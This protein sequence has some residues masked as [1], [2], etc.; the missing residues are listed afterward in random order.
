MAIKVGYEP[1]GALGYGAVAAG[2]AQM[3][4]QLRRERARA[5]EQANAA[6]LAENAR[7]M[8]QEQQYQANKPRD[9]IREG[10]VRE[11]QRVRGDQLDPEIANR[12]TDWR[13]ETVRKYQ[14]QQDKFDL[15][16]REYTHRQQREL[17]ELDDAEA[18]LQSDTRFNAAEKQ[19]A[20]DQ[21]NAKR[22]GVQPIKRREPVRPLEE[23][24]KEDSYRDPDGNV[25]IRDKNGNIDYKHAPK[26]EK[27]P[28]DPGSGPTFSEDGNFYLD[29]NKWKPYREQAE[30]AQKPEFTNADYAKVLKE[31][32]KEEPPEDE[33]L[34]SRE[35]P[36]LLQ[37]AFD[38]L[39]NKRGLNGKPPGPDEIRAEAEKMFLAEWTSIDAIKRRAQEKID[40][41]RQVRDESGG[42]GV[43]S[44]PPS[45]IVRPQTN[46]GYL[47]PPGYPMGDVSAPMPPQ[48]P[49]EQMT[50][51]PAPPEIQQQ[52][53]Q[54]TQTQPARPEEIQRAR[55]EYAQTPVGGTY[56]DPWGIVR[57]KSAR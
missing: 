42:N 47:P 41:Q 44:G 16:D 40:L 4:E 28:V 57:I 37:S 6:N 17:D 53:A 23:V 1:V 33:V 52:A 27:V 21:I 5:Q 50:P 13:D 48:P 22:Y 45:S 34:A 39:S 7:L 36:K 54:I 32:Q 3:A 29:D 12:E 46:G 10:R 11:N 24:L 8:R 18:R 26:P 19:Y 15:Q 25:Y 30:K 20:L 51:Q 31:A 35:D 14:D 49:P 43:P 9:Y 2:E 56:R 55:A 38:A